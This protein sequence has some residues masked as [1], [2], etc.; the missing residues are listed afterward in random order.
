MKNPRHLALSLLRHCP[1]RDND[2]L[3]GDLVERF[4]GGDKRL[5]FGNKLW[6]RS[7]SGSPAGA[8]GMG[9]TDPASA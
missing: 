1:G 7:R 9:M 5:V 4:S 8:A 3:A 2:A 6:L